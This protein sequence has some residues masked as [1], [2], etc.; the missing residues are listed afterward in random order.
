VGKAMLQVA[1]SGY[2]RQILESADINEAARG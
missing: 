1:R 2:R